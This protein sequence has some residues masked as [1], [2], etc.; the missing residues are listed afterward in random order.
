MKFSA[1]VLASVVLIGCGRAPVGRAYIDYQRVALGDPLDF[2]E[3]PAVPSPPSAVPGESATLPPIPQRKLDF[4]ENVARLE[5]VQLAV[6][7]ARDQSAKQLARKLR[8]AYLKE[9]DAVEND[10]MLGIGSKKSAALDRAWAT[11]RNRF[12]EYANARAPHA[13]R[14]ALYAGFP[15]PDPNSQRKPSTTEKALLRRFERA[16]DSREALSELGQAYE[17]DVRKALADYDDEVTSEILK[18]RAEIEQMRAEAEARA[19]Q[20]AAKQVSELTQQ[21]ESVLSGRAAVELPAQP[22]VTAKAEAGEPV[23]PAPYV[24]MRTRSEAEADRLDA[25]R[26][27]AEIWAAHFGVELVKSPREGQ[28]RTKEFLE[29][30]KKRHFGP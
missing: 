10:R 15:D 1:L 21:I 19:I 30:R 16:R 26:S 13:I 17:S 18:V 20:D 3:P 24:K 22:E 2:K 11:I 28:D 14:L 23:R 29:W 5:K 27:D 7:E 12:L 6:D 4:S 9:I 25:V 8:E